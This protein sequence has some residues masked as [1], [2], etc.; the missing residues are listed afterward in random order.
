MRIILGLNR[1]TY[2]YVDRKIMQEKIA[3]ASAMHLLIGEE[4]LVSVLPQEIVREIL[5]YI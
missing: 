1:K 2:L 5:D 3:F 4:S